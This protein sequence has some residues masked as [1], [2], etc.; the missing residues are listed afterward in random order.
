MDVT[1]KDVDLTLDIEEMLFSPVQTVK[2]RQG[3]L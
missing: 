3:C 2:N 1:R